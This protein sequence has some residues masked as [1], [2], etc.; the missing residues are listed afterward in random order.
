M[1]GG[2]RVDGWEA[3]QSL[4]GLRHLSVE[5]TSK[6]DLV[7]IRVLKSLEV[8]AIGGSLHQPMRIPDLTPLLNCSNLKA[9]DL[10]G[11]VVKQLQPEVIAFLQ[12]IDYLNAPDAVLR[13]M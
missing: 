2:N 5:W 6:F 1:Q 8:L 11:A 4:Q 7:H 10:A 13:R 12:S 3:L 9:L